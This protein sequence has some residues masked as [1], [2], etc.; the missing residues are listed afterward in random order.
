MFMDEFWDA[1]D[2]NRQ[3]LGMRLKRGNPIPSG[4]YHTVIHVVIFNYDGMFLSQ[5]RAAT[6]QWPNVWDFSVGGSALCGETSQEAAA[7]EL[8]EE[9]GLKRDF[10]SLKPVFTHKGKN[11]FDDYYF[12]FENT[13]LNTLKLQKDEVQNVQ[14]ISFE[15][16]RKGMKLGIFLP[17]NCFDVVE[18]MYLKILVEKKLPDDTLIYQL[19]QDDFKQYYEI[20]ELIKNKSSNNRPAD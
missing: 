18:L 1:I 11:Y 2:E 4:Y 15:Q 5:L 6:K 16:A 8:Y 19:D 3:Y 17:H 20:Q 10:S 13:N 12:L 14:W 7:R 9:L